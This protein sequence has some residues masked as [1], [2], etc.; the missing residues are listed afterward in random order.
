[1][2]IIGG[3][4]TTYRRMAED[5][6]RKLETTLRWKRTTSATRH[7]PLHGAANNMNWDD[8]WYF[9]G[10]D[11]PHLKRLAAVQPE[12]QEELSREYHIIRAQVVW[13]VREEMARNVE[14]FL[15]RRTRLLFLD[16]G[17]ALRIAPA[18]ARIMAEELRRD[19]HWVA[20]QIS[21]FAE[22]TKAYLPTST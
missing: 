4:W 15:A 21:S 5:V 14:D 7:L 11:V 17:E 19:E 1:V 2:T 13:A 10:S 20:A 8:P 16:A 3:K 6:L 22:E 18:V 9:Y 12:L